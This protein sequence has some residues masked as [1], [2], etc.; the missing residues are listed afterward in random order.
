MGAAAAPVEEMKRTSSRIF[1]GLARSYER[2]LDYATLFQDRRWKIW[3]AR[4]LSREGGSLILDVGSGTLVLEELL[5]GEKC[6]F[7]CLDLAPEMIRVAAEKRVPNVDLLLNGDAEF[8]PFPEGSFDS[9]VSCYV[10]KYVDV[11]KFARE[12]A[13]VAKPG[14][15]VVLYDFAKPRGPL[16][17]FLEAYIRAGLRLVGAALGLARRGEAFTFARLPRIIEE[18]A[19]DVEVVGAMESSGFVEVE[20]DRLTGGVVFACSGMRG[21]RL[22]TQRERRRP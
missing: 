2:A 6:R 16:A 8:L 12:L 20:S 13:R 22:D 3:A 9:V 15:T 17:P 10:P 1:A 5:A 18:T 4:R 11:K 14:G 7:V 19:W 21:E